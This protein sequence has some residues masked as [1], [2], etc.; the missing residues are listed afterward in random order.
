MPDFTTIRLGS[1]KRCCLLINVP[2]Q[3]QAFEL[4][5][6]VDNAIVRFRWVTDIDDS[7]ITV[8]HEQLLRRDL[9]LTSIKP[10]H[11]SSALI[12]FRPVIY[13]YISA[14][15]YAHNG[16]QMSSSRSCNMK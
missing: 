9:I 7:Q 12:T 1:G 15:R 10:G 3:S 2:A 14:E 5:N 11:L 16:M 6:S 4:S 8:E 13:D